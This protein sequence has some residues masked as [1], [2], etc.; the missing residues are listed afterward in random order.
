MEQAV[1]SQFLVGEKEACGGCHQRIVLSEKPA[2]IGGE[3]LLPHPERHLG[4]CGERT[5]VVVGLEV[6]VAVQAHSDWGPT[7]FILNP[8]P[9]EAHCLGHTHARKTA[10]VRLGPILNICQVLPVEIEVGFIQL[11]NA[12]PQIGRHLHPYIPMPERGRVPLM[13]V[14]GCRDHVCNAGLGARILDTFLDGG[15]IQIDVAEILHI[16]SG[17]IFGSDF[18]NCGAIPEIVPPGCVQRV[19]RLQQCPRSDRLRVSLAV[20]MRGRGDDSEMSVCKR[21]EGNGDGQRVG[22]RDGNVTSIG[23]NR[24]KRTEGAVG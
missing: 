10:H 16:L 22:D 21:P 20:V 24:G 7:G 19:W 5:R 12:S 4:A 13:R 17:A 8:T 11:R 18:D 6:R 2:I 1:R 14:L 23:G 9:V 3:I 15:D